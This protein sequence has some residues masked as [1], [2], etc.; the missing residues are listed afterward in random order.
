[1]INFSK[2]EIKDLILSVLGIALIFSYPNFGSFPLF[3]LVVVIS[4]VFH[5]LA[6]RSLAEKFGYAA[7]YKM[8]PLGLI[9]AL[10]FAIGS[11]GL[12]KFVAPGAVYILPRAFGRWKFKTR[13]SESEMGLIS[14][15]GPAVNLFFGVF[16]GLFSGYIFN[17]LSMIN[18][19]LAFIN[20][21]PIPPLDGS[22]VLRWKPWLW[23]VVF[24]ISLVLFWFR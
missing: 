9:I 5:E 6:H 13:S 14:L 22:K 11:G 3:L 19:W 8:W 17:V 7:I 1:M 10:F 21:L 4:F 20:L 16:F 12:I 15:S 2:A 18:L 24:I 23:L